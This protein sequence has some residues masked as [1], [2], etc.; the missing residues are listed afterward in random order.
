MKSHDGDQP[1]A[2]KAC[3]PTVDRHAKQGTELC[4]S[5]A[6]KVQC[7]NVMAH[8]LRYLPQCQHITISQTPHI[9][10]GGHCPHLAI[11]T[12]LAPVNALRLVNYS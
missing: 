12:H 9:S 7:G 8:Q 3:H 5:D 10:I 2:Q 11:N 1:C 4:L 6:C